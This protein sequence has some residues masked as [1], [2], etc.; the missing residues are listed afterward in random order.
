MVF[1]VLLYI[2]VLHY[3]SLPIYPLL[4][5]K[6]C[7]HS[8]TIKNA[9]K[10]GIFGESDSRRLSNCLQTHIF[11]NFNDI[12]RICNQINYRNIW[13][14][15]VI[16][17]LIMTAQVL[18]MFF[19]KKTCTLIPLAFCWTK[20]ESK[21]E[22]STHSFTEMNFVLEIK[23]KTVMSW[24]SRKKKECIFFQRLFCP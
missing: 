17:I 9:K 4:F 16:M 18:S 3:I 14:P 5:P 11:W 7:P 12:S 22:N 21:M 10:L 19:Q 23:I 1:L 13:F 15:K 20:T 2:H 24:T 6:F 8:K